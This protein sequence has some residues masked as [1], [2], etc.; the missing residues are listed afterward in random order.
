M[1]EEKKN[2]GPLLDS[3][4]GKKPL[5]R[6][7]AHWA[8]S[9]GEGLPPLEGEKYHSGKEKKTF[10]EKKKDFWQLEM[11]SEGGREDWQGG[12]EKEKA[13]SFPEEPRKWA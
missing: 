8:N 4:W 13:K 9:S 11:E 7:D 6:W 3:L 12:M 5:E 10:G 1:R 2:C